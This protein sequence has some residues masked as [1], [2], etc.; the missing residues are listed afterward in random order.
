MLSDR[1]KKI[2]CAVVDG[3]IDKSTPISSKDI[4]ENYLPECS[5][6]TIRN[7]LSALESMGY[8]IQ[9]HVSA[10]RIPSEKAFR[11]YVDQLATTEPLTADEVQI[12]QKYFSQKISTMEEVITAVTH[13]ISDVTNYTSVVVKSDMSDKILAIRLVDL[14]NGKLLAV[15]VTDSRV[16]KD[17]IVDIPDDFTD[18]ILQQAE[19]WLNNVFVGKH[20]SEFVNFNYPYTLINSQFEKYNAV[21]K[22]I[23]DVLKKVS[24]ENGM[25]VE[26]YGEN[27]IFQHSEYSQVQSAEKFLTQMEQKQHIARLF[28]DDGGENGSVT[29]KIGSED[30]APEG[31]S[32]VTARV[33]LGENVSG[34]IGVI[35][36][37]RMNYKK[38]LCVLDKISNIIIDLVGNDVK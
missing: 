1:K 14:R 29:I 21:F 33:P 28:T 6:A 32:V 25:D 10:G 13:I 34:S 12:I 22:K 26:T 31:C 27:K 30:N 5:S 24:L 3:Y 4:Q 38:V 17:G 23:I 37:V 16:L 19:R 2:L 20:V 18:A 11:F 9:P 35:G 8:L 7:E 36:P 15:I